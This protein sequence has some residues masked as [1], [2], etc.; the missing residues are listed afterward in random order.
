MEI[1]NFKISMCR[2]NYD[3]EGDV[4]DCDTTGIK[5]EFDYIY[6][7]NK[8]SSE[9]VI[10]RRGEIIVHSD[11]YNNELVLGAK[12]WNFHWED[13]QTLRKAIKKE[14]FTRLAESLSDNADK[15]DEDVF[16]VMEDIKA[17]RKVYDKLSFYCLNPHFNW[18]EDKQKGGID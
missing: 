4:G 14:I 17:L 6:Y 11:E 15:Y 8:R 5:F 16:L 2:N 18:L 12:F 13:I 1:G 7:K 9:Q 3:P 10:E